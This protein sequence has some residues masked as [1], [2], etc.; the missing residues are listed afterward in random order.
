MWVYTHCFFLWVVLDLKLQGLWIKKRQEKGFVLAC[1][2]REYSPSKQGDRTWWQ[3][4][5]V[6][7]HMAS[8]LRWDWIWTWDWIWSRIQLDNFKACPPSDP[9]QMALPP[10]GL[11]TK[12]QTHM[13]RG[14]A[15]VGGGG[16][17]ERNHVRRKCIL[18]CYR[19]EMKRNKQ[20]MRWAGELDTSLIYHQIQSGSC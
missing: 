5:E 7:A 13:G 18:P 16:K 10:T 11:E 15:G 6:G 1:S 3:K 2:A 14:G 20:I 19:N 17:R 4:W 8:T 9:F 12:C